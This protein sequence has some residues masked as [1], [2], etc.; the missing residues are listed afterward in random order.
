[1]Q[2]RF[3]EDATKSKF[4]GSFLS[5]SFIGDTD[6]I[7]VPSIGG[8]EVLDVDCCRESVIAVVA[9]RLSAE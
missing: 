9:D 2:L 4:T 7:I 6:E 5:A 3:P 8:H 1:M